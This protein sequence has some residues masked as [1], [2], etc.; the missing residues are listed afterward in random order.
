LKNRLT[1]FLPLIILLSS[2]IRVSAGLPFV[3]ER[4]KKRRRRL[5]K[6]ANEYGIARKSEE[7]IAV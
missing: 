1:T 5:Q 2:I 3:F 6:N 7:A 4:S